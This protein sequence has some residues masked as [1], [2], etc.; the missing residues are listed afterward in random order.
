[1]SEQGEL[2]VQYRSMSSRLATTQLGSLV[3][4][5]TLFA[6][7]VAKLLSGDCL[8]LTGQSRGQQYESQGKQRSLFPS[9][10]RLIV[11]DRAG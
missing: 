10:L 9:A 7:P 6:V 3:A 4:G 2:F 11:S 5:K 1:V 8:A